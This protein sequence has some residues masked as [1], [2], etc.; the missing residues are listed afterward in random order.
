MLLLNILGNRWGQIAYDG[1]PEEKIEMNLI[2]LITIFSVSCFARKGK[3]G[4]LLGSH[5]TALWRGWETLICMFKMFPVEALWQGLKTW[6]VIEEWIWRGDWK[7]V[8]EEDG[9]DFWSQL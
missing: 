5:K 7:N 6:G 1:K 3:D 2:I 9:T 8:Q 4:F